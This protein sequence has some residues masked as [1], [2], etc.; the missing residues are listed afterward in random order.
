MNSFYLNNIHSKVH[1]HRR[2]LSKGQ[3]AFGLSDASAYLTKTGAGLTGS[4]AMSW[5]VAFPE[6][7][8]KLISMIAAS[9]HWTFLLLL[10]I[11]AFM[12]STVLNMEHT[13]PAEKKG[14]VYLIE[15]LES[16]EGAGEESRRLFEEEGLMDTVFAVLLGAEDEGAKAVP[17]FFKKMVSRQMTK[18]EEWTWKAIKG[19]YAVVLKPLPARVD[20]A[21]STPTS[22]FAGEDER[23]RSESVLPRAAPSPSINIDAAVAVMAA[24]KPK[25]VGKMATFR[26]GW[27]RIF[28]IRKKTSFPRVTVASLSVVA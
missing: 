2:F 3:R 27:R 22:S 23:D 13:A 5:A 14:Q 11:F 7:T 26:A 28:R 24:P 20:T 19:R 8:C 1:H 9:P 16:G 21:P 12:L 6:E 10:L 17:P 4:V 15:T 25:K 18:I